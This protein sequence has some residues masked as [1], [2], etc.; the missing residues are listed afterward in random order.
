MSDIEVE[1]GEKYEK[2]FEGNLI[3]Y[4][5]NQIFFYYKNQCYQINKANGYCFPID[6]EKFIKDQINSNLINTNYF[7]NVF[8]NYEFNLEV[9]IHKYLTKKIIAYNSYAFYYYNDEYIC[10]NGFNKVVA[11]MVYG[12]LL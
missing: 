8:R 2:F 4:N 10:F 7:N 11:L 1:R 12:S 9:L 5:F 3:I 6:D